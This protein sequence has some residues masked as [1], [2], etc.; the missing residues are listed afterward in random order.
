MQALNVP[1]AGVDRSA[2]EEREAKAV[3]PFFSPKKCDL[4]IKR[5]LIDI[6]EQ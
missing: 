4:W 2:Q 6:S 3:E 1:F 5:H